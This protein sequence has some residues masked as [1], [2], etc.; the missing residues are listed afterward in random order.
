MIIIWQGLG[1]LALLIPIGFSLVAQ[2]ATDAIFEKGFY[3]GH[4]ALATVALL[5]SSAVVWVVGIKL[6]SSPSQLLVDPKT[7]QQFE[8]KKKH[9]IFWIPMQWFSPVIAA[10][11]MY[12][13][14]K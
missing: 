11:A 1:F 5:I 10:I 12:A 6:N 4:S 8:F 2:V 3:T 14:F 9:T 7:G 13:A